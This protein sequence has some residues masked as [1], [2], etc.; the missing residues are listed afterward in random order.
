VAAAHNDP[1]AF[2]QAIRDWRAQGGKGTI[3]I[4]ALAV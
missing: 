1:A 3:W 2:E 4:V